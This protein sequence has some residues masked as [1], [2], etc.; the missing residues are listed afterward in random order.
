M[1]S[2]DGE[3]TDVT[4]RAIGYVRVSTDEQARDGVSLDAQAGKIRAYAILH[5][6]ELLDV[7]I[8]AGE[9]GGTPLAERAGG[10][11][12]MDAIRMRQAD[13]VIVYRLDR[14]GRRTLDVLSLVENVTRRG[15]AL[16]SITEKLDTE[17]AIG[18]FVL[19][20]LASLA[21]ME[22]DQVR[23]RTRMAMQHIA[24]NSRAVSRPPRG[25]RIVD[26]RFEPDPGSDGLRML[27]RA[28]ELRTQ[29]LTYR[30]IAATLHAEGFRPERGTRMSASTVRYMLRNPRLRDVTA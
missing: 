18:R 24:A 29:E 30:A 22:R 27:T 7:I 4:K 12:I 8:D 20:T 15:I 25:L 19:R 14:L 21:E 17:S 3:P 11:R 5:E 2:N 1:Q 13:A 26:G 9:S 6:L 10:A 23:D 28:R 16:H